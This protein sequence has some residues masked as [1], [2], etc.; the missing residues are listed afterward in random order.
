M[1][2]TEE[3]IQILV[4]DVTQV[5]SIPKSEVE[6]KLWVIFEQGRKA[7]LI[8][9]RD[10]LLHDGKKLLDGFAHPKDCKFCIADKL[11]NTL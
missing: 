2:P 9:A 4:R 10:Y 6:R 11:D 1:N 8:E 3:L 7:G 5:G